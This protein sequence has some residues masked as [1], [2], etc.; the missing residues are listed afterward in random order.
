MCVQGVPYPESE[1]N[2]MDAVMQFAQKHL[3]FAPEQTALFGWSIGGYTVTWAAMN[4]PSVRFVLLDATFDDI[5]DLAC[6][7]MP[8]FAEGLVRYSVRRHINLNNA[9]QLV[10]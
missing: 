6:K 3:H 8:K 7:T 2:A 10:R 9:K 5:E 4:Y 1:Q